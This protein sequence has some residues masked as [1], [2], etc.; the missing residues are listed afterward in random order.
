MS[1]TQ[2]KI[3]VLLSVGK[4]RE[5]YNDLE[6]TLDNI[7]NILLEDTLDIDA[8]RTAINLYKARHS[9]RMFSDDT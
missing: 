4:L 5:D 2:D 8:I 9:V 7:T 3:M 1:N 6:E